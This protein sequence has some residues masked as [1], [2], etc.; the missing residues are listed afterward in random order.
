MILKYDELRLSIACEKCGLE[1]INDIGSKILEDCKNALNLA[2]SGGGM[3]FG[4]HDIECK[5]NP[6]NITIYTRNKKTKEGQ[7]LEY[8]KDDI[9]K[10][11]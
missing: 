6:S 5:Y 8:N 3:H 7:H 9:E 4:S 1:K 2:H 11:I 10:G